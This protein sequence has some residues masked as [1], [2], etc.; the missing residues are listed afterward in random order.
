MI[1]YSLHDV[2]FSYG[3]PT[4]LSVPQLEI[5]AGQVTVLVGPNGSGKTTLLHLL[6]FLAVPT[7]GKLRFFGEAATPDRL[8]SLR[9]RVSLLLQNPY[10]F[11]SSVASNV[12]WGLKIR[13]VSA[14]DRRQ[15]T[16]QALELVGLTDYRG[17]DA[18]ALSGGEGQRLALARLLALEP[19][20]LLL[21]EPT[22][23]L[24]V[25]TR[26][27]VEE[28]LEECVSTRGT[29]VVMATHDGAQ[30][31]RL[32]ANIW[33]LE[34]GRV[35]EGEPDNVLRGRIS[36]AEPGIF[37]TGRLR[38]RVT[39]AVEDTEC[40]RV[41][42]REIFLAREAHPSSARNNLRG[43]IVGAELLGSAEVRVTVDCDEKLL[44]MITRESWNDLGLTVGAAVVLSFKATAVQPC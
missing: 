1:A 26:K 6:A 29:T 28:I 8:M 40:V 32:G 3:G 39:Q 35:R 34:G 11:H 20:V 9:R 12:G 15:R 37:D 31:Q 22:N 27:R 38:L 44:V 2:G 23:H 36:S 21:D 18:H 30:A 24:D 10:L 13:G 25:E 5:P 33:R 41:G 4:V 19:E 7:G 14:A 42:P 17:R 43:V 16:R